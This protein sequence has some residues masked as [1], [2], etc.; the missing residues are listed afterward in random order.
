MILFLCIILLQVVIGSPAPLDDTGPSG[1][2]MVNN[3]MY[4]Y[5]R[6]GAP[7]RP[8]FDRSPVRPYFDRSSGRPY[9][10]MYDN[11]DFD[12]VSTDYIASLLLFALLRKSEKLI[13]S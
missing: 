2:S 6:C 12:N 5:R 3:S 8:Y 13:G 11:R 4:S 10:R 1:N 7:V 9:V